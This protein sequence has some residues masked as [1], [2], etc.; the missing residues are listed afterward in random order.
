[1]KTKSR[2]SSDLA[3][4]DGPESIERL[5][6]L[7]IEEKSHECGRIGLSDHGSEITFLCNAG[8]SDMI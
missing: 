7:Y 4:E 1:M 6:E 8:R 2:S 5:R 3:E